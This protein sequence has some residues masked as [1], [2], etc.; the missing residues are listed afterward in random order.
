MMNEL[1]KGGEGGEST[2]RCISFSDEER[3]LVRLPDRIGE[4]AYHG[5][6]LGDPLGRLSFRASHKVDV[7]TMICR[8]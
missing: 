3:K 1:M 2:V 6:I 7:Q 5:I 4:V 8:R